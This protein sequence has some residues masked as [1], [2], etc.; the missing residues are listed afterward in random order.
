MIDIFS[1]YR[2]K[3]RKITYLCHAA[4]AHIY[5]KIITAEGAVDWVTRSTVSSK[6]VCGNRC[7]LLYRAAGSINYIV[8]FDNYEE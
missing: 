2:K 5:A 4:L 6:M 8:V 7:V 1:F 3:Y